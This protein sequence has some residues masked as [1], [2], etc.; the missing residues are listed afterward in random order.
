[1]TTSDL[2]VWSRCRRD[3]LVTGHGIEAGK[4]NHG[5]EERT[6]AGTSQALAIIGTRLVVGIRDLLWCATYHGDQPYAPY[7]C[8]ASCPSRL[9]FHPCSDQTRRRATDECRR[10]AVDIARE[11]ERYTSCAEAAG[12]VV[13]ADGRSA[14]AGGG[15]E[16]A[17][18]VGV[19]DA[20]AAAGYAR[21]R[22]ET[23]AGVEAASCHSGTAGRQTDC[24]ASTH[25]LERT[26]LKIAVIG[27]CQAWLVHTQRSE[28]C[29]SRR[30]AE[31][32]GDQA[33]SRRWIGW[34]RVARRSWKGVQMREAADQGAEGPA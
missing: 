12:R 10:W 17:A 25:M 3:L 13:V 19:A 30:I 9:H 14:A 6:L 21:A 24:P 29:E 15:G 27:P 11:L 4:D 7:R 32:G 28:T 26:W 20:A 31:M 18:V 5:S 22:E 23:A 1:M 33:R 34:L 16:L 8:S 2:E